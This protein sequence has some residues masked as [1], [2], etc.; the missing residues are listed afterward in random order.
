MIHSFAKLITKILARWLA[1]RIQTLVSHAQ[2]VFI[3]QRCIQDNFLYVR[4]LARAYHR[5][6]THALLF[7]LDISEAFDTVSWEYMLV[8][9]EHRGISNRWREWLTMLF[10]TSHSTVLSNGAVGRRINHARGL[11]Q[12]DLLSPYLLSLAIDTLP[13]VLETATEEGAL[14]LMLGR[15][16]RLRLSLYADDAVIFINPVQSEATALFSILDD[17]GQA[18][19]LWLNLEKCMVAP[20]KMHGTKFGSHPGKLQRK[21]GWLPDNIH[22][23]AADSWPVEGSSCARGC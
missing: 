14:S 20:N 19:G 2:S 4:N 7:K 11:R 1:A 6:K 9:L 12:G 16:A 5:T 8:L 22:G 17:F 10:R 23:F 13:R 3:K 21:K 18:K 15:Q